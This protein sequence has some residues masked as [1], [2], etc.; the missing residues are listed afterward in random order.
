MASPFVLDSK[1][2]LGSMKASD[3]E[4]INGAYQAGEDTSANAI[5]QRGR[6]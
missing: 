1:N 2:Y 6:S 5:P 3:R 4:T